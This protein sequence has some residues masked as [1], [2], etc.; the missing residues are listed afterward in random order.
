MLQFRQRAVLQR[1]V[2]P[3]R[4]FAA[5]LADACLDGRAEFGRRL[6]VGEVEIER[7]A[8]ERAHAASRGAGEALA[9]EQ[10][11]L[12]RIS[13]RTRHLSHPEQCVHV[14]GGKRPVGGAAAE[15]ERRLIRIVHRHG[16]SDEQASRMREGVTKSRQKVGRGRRVEHRRAKSSDLVAHD[17]DGGVVEGERERESIGF[18]AGGRAAPKV[19]RKWRSADGLAPLPGRLEPG[20]PL[21]TS[22]P[23]TSSRHAIAVAVHR[24]QSRRFRRYDRRGT[25]RPRADVRKQRR[26]STAAPNRR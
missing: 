21:G 17:G 5:P 8:D 13:V 12:R 7:Q 11:T 19:E 20:E 22:E 10:R 15:R 26:G 2:A 16:F 23:R 1:T 24:L 14:A 4:H 18:A 6:R 3:R 25:R 9:I